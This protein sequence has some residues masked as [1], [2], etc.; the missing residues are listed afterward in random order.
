MEKV[1]RRKC[2]YGMK[3]KNPGGEMSAKEEAAAIKAEEEAAERNLTG[4]PMME[5]T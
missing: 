1:K 5:H 4:G 2:R 3:C